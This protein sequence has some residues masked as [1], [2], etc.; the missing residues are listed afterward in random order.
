VSKVKDGETAIR[1]Y[2]AAAYVRNTQIETTKRRAAV[3]LKRDKIV[4]ERAKWFKRLTTTCMLIELRFFCFVTF[5]F[6]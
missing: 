3:R 4:S 2:Y 6:L 1:R 5:L